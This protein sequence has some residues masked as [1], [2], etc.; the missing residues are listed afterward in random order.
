MGRL[1]TT[2]RLQAF[3]FSRTLMRHTSQKLLVANDRQCIREPKS[4]HMLTSNFLPRE[5]C[6]H[7]RA[8]ANTQTTWLQQTLASCHLALEQLASFH[9]SHTTPNRRPRPAK[10]V[11]RKKKISKNTQPRTIFTFQLFFFFSP[12]SERGGGEVGSCFINLQIKPA[13]LKEAE[14]VSPGLSFWRSDFTC[15]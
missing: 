14:C 6:S 15:S 3:S 5:G 10:S 13:V 1:K 8:R 7:A 4:H 9:H 12:N 2:K 11:P